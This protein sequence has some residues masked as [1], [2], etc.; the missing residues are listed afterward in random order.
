MGFV[1]TN[2]DLERIY[3]TPPLRDFL[4]VQ[5]LRYIAHIVRR[6]NDHPTKTAL[7]IE[8][9]KKNVKSVW[10]KVQ[11]LLGLDR[12]D[13]I[14]KMVKREEFEG[15]LAERF[16]FLRARATGRPAQGKSLPVQQRNV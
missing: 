15:V 9:T 12:D 16:T 10:T 3:G 1:L 7:F 4:H 8:A 5:F 11:F 2:T 14:N 6:P 13:I